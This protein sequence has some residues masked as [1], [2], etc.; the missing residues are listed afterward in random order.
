MST[1]SVLKIV[2]YSGLTPKLNFKATYRFQRENFAIQVASRLSRKC[3]K[4][5]FKTINQPQA[6]GKG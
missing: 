5:A 1:F 6:S 3:M 2:V 4:N